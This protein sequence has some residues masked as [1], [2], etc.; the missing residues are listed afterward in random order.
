M[1]AQNKKGTGM[2]AR[3][4][5][6]LRSGY[7]NT[8]QDVADELGITV[9]QVSNYISV[10]ARQGYVRPTRLRMP[11]VYGRGRELRVFEVIA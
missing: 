10:F 8:S 9:R 7:C 1:S 5:K 2:K 6:A 3:V 11:N 4:L